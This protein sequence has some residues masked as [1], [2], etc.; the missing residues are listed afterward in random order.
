MSLGILHHGLTDHGFHVWWP[1]TIGNRS[2]PILI[3]QLIYSYLPNLPNTLGRSSLYAQLRQ[4]RL[5]FSNI[6]LLVGG[7]FRK[8]IVFHRYFSIGNSPNER[9]KYNADSD[10]NLLRIKTIYRGKKTLTRSLLNIQTQKRPFCELRKRIM[11]TFSRLKIYFNYVS[12]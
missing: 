11:T 12:I 10:Q 4:R 6:Y 3:C 2:R 9:D 8:T 5:I 1:A 7:S